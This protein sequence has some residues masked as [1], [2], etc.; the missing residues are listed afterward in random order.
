MEKFS[1]IL[2]FIKTYNIFWHNFNNI[3]RHLIPLPELV[4]KI[5][6][7][8]PLSFPFSR[9]SSR[10]YSSSYCAWNT[11]QRSL[12]CL[13]K[14]LKKCLIYFEFFL[15]VYTI[16]QL[17]MQISNYSVF[18]FFFAYVVFFMS[19]KNFLFVRNYVN[20]GIYTLAYMVKV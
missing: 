9:M 7:P 10:R 15:A 8:S 12:K 5:Y 16:G 18:F 4:S 1:H 19:Q 11:P 3:S 6:R 13:I 17:L 14:C 20:K 2:P